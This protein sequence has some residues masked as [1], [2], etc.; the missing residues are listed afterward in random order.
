M[1]FLKNVLKLQDTVTSDTGLE[2]LQKLIERENS[3][4]V[5]QFSS[6][7]FRVLCQNLIFANKG[8]GAMLFVGIAI[9]N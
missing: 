9:F 5:R 6:H 2:R 7:N 4:V 3:D 8:F 1:G